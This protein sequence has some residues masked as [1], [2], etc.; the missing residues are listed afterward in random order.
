MKV[1]LVNGSPNENG[2]TYTAL[3]EVASAL[4]EC[5]I[6]TEIF[7]IGKESVHGCIACNACSSM[8]KCVF[9][10][11]KCNELAVRI[12]EAD[13]IIIGTP[14]YFAGPNGALC[15]LLDRAF[16]SCPAD[17]RFKPGAAV[18]SCRRGGASAAFDRINK[19]FT[20]RQMPVVSSVYWN[21][22]HGNK[23]EEVMKDREGL[24]TM[25][26]LGRNM[27]FLLKS[28]SESSEPF[29]ENEIRERTNFSHGK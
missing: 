7:Q 13:G 20:I 17:L 5:G 16:Y 9:D 23:P 3:S 21:S 1:L 25:R 27:A 6:D 12:T 8:G 24:Q 18:V 22:V 4:N 14:V 26:Y 10:D 29:P 2:C 15:A 28:I 19:Y 11:D